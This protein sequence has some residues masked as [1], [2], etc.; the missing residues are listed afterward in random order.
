MNQLPLILCFAD[1]YPQAQR[2]AR[3]TALPFAEINVHQFPDGESKL[4][5]PV[6]LSSHVI[7]Y[8]SLDSPNNKLLEVLLAAR[9]LREQSVQTLT[10]MAPYLC[11]MRQDKAFNP[12]EI[13]S[14]RV[15]GQLLAEHFDAVLTVDSHLHRIDSLEQAIPARIA[16]NLS[17]T[18]PL[19]TLLQKLFKNT[20]LLGPDCE[21]Q[22]WVE[23]ITKAM[24]EGTADYCV[25][26]KQRFGDADV[27][28][29]LPAFD[30]SNRHVVLVDDVAST[31]YT[32]E[33]T[34]RAVSIF[35]P[36]S[37]SILVTHA[38]FVGDALQRLHETGVDNI[39]SSDS[40]SHIT[41]KVALDSVLKDG[42]TSCFT[43][44]ESE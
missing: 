14:Q 4:T 18:Q 26:S 23:A 11:Y 15:I 7:I 37:L 39:W 17:A 30:F 19:A 9:G 34:A 42:L 28:I 10:L 31:G 20:V 1:S 27:Q 25:A 6:E 16:L 5:L 38:L 22:Q 3:S 29:S 40:I 33:Q 2:L 43:T 8:R 12:G 41:N 32:L 13:V 36:A 21:S 44:L 24:T 35:A